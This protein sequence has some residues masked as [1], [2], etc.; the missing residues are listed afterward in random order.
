MTP[1][2]DIVFQLLAFFIMTFQISSLEGDFSVKMPLA[3]VALG[4]LD[5]V[6]PP[7]HI[8]LTA[9]EDGQLSGI[10]MANRPLESFAALHE[11]I[12]G[13]VGRE[14]G[15]GSLAEQ[16]EV[17]LDCDYNLRYENVV[18]AI[19]AISGYVSPDR[20]VVKLIEKINFAPPRRGETPT[21]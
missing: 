12:I 14:G 18:E 1:M 17:E 4:K 7:I 10:R 21:G 13:L 8:R 15:P 19:T 11:E 6:L 9:G 16:A 20:R 2:I 3:S 5:P